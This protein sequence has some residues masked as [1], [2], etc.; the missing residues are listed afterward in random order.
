LKSL[1][2]CSARIIGKTR[3]I[4]QQSR[5]AAVEARCGSVDIGGIGIAGGGG[6]ILPLQFC[7]GYDYAAHF[8]G[9]NPVFPHIALDDLDRELRRIAIDLK[10][11]IR[12][13]VALFLRTRELADIDCPTTER[14]RIWWWAVKASRYAAVY[15]VSRREARSHADYIREHAALIDAAGRLIDQ[16]AGRARSSTT[17]CIAGSLTTRAAS[18]TRYAE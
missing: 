18:A 8:S 3:L 11:P 12:D 14:D 16:T 1:K 9:E 2:W 4:E 17:S 5:G 7:D 15:F 6:P 13:G 10:I